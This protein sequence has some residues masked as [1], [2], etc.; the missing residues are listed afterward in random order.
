M[1][2][3]GKLIENVNNIFE[4]SWWLD[5]VSP[6][7]W[8]EITIEESGKVIARL[9]YCFK[10]NK[11]IMPDFTQ[12]CGI[13][14]DNGSETNIQK[15]ILMT[16]NILEKV[17]EELDKY[18]SV[19]LRLDASFRYFL[20]FYW[21]GYTVVPKITYRIYDLDNLRA[22]YE[23][24][25]KNVKRDIKYAERKVIIDS[26]TSSE[27]MISLLKKTFSEQGRKL[28]CSESLI[29]K[30]ILECEQRKCG[31]MFTAVD[32]EGNIHAAAY[33]VYDKNIC[34]YLFAGRDSKFKK[35]NAQTLIIWK[36][37]EFAS[38]VSNSFDFE[39]SMIRGIENY[40]RRFGGTPT[41][42]YAIEKLSISE[43]ICSIVKSSVKKFL[44][45]K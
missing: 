22:V 21:K 29:K 14:I 12:V 44:G 4:S 25:S 16:E 13:W 15:Q 11:V 6:N 43:K 19:Q 18:N 35:S 1:N 24:F 17:L 37:I 40:F 31:K 36:C 39:G 34:Y 28:P 41:V 26:T 9:P 42:Y 20:P 45:Y 7:H 2:W 27:N 38:N 10:N 5:I 23:R 33:V 32:K 3:S 30:I 8:K